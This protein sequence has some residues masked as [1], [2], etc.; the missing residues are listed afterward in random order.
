MPSEGY[1]S[2]SVCVC[3]CVCLSVCLCVCYHSSCFSICLYT[4]TQINY[5]LVCGRVICAEG[6]HFSTFHYNR[7]ELKHEEERTEMLQAKIHR[8]QG[9][10][11]EACCRTQ[12]YG[13]PSDNNFTHI[14]SILETLFATCTIVR[15]LHMT[16]K[17]K[18]SFSL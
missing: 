9:D 2:H 8:L 13:K 5:S 16:Y 14:A 3:G 7:E 17:Q 6:L 12:E 10:I 18:A 15:K 1:S 11:K 4:C